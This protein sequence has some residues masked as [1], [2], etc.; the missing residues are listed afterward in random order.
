MAATGAELDKLGPNP[1]APFV[2]A[3]IA[4]QC[5]DFS[6]GDEETNTTT[7]TTGAERV[8]FWECVCVR[9]AVCPTGRV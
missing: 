8:A 9:V 4:R 1:S 7:T 6:G 3:F 2:W 5:A